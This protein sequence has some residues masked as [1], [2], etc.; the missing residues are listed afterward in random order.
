MLIKNLYRQV[1]IDPIDKGANKLYI[2]SGF[3]SG[4]FAASHLREVLSKN[5]EVKVHLIHGMHS[6]KHPTSHSIFL[7]LLKSYPKNFFGY[8]IKKSSVAV[9]SKVYAWFN[10]KIPVCGFSGSSN[11]SEEAFNQKKQINQ[12][13]IDDAM[14]VKRY[15]DLLKKD[16]E[17]MSSGSPSIIKKPMSIV[18]PTAKKSSISAFPASFP[19]SVAPGEAKWLVPN[20]EIQISLLQKRFTGGFNGVTPYSVLNW[21]ASPKRKSFRDANQSYITLYGDSR[22]FGF[23][24]PR[25]KYFKLKTDDGYLLD[26]SVQQEADKSDP[27][28][29]KAIASNPNDQLGI[30]LR[31]RLG[32]PSGHIITT[33]DLTDYGRTDFILKKL[34]K[35]EFLFDF[36]V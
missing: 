10:D 18:P 6:G 25:G 35:N 26:C 1:L 22:K 16:A 23:L 5:R 13:Q 11:Y 21:G 24:P 2:V 28:I 20:K 34:D 8:Y 19:H 12:M 15:F 3:S 33:D 29:G 14:E 7:S 36:H 32:V 27:R 4:A 30:Y 9:H 17:L 31:K